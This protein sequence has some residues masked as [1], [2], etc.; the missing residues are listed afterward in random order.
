M[1]VRW[2]LSVALTIFASGLAWAGAPPPAQPGDL[3]IVHACLTSRTASLSSTCIVVASDACLKGATSPQQRAQCMTRERAVWDLFL[4]NDY[5]ALMANLRFK[6]RRELRIIERRFLA[7]TE[8]RCNFVRTAREREYAHDVERAEIEKCWMQATAVQWLWLRD[9][10]D[11][12]KPE[13]FQ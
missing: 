4:N 6:A 13:K 1:M 11:L 3:Q 10:V 2:H 12:A 9:F 5:Q 8:R 7:A